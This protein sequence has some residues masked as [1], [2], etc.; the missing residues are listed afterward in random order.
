M[1][2]QKVRIHTILLVVRKHA[3]ENTRISNYF[4]ILEAI[5]SLS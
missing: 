3:F 4:D 1:T 2:G 5:K